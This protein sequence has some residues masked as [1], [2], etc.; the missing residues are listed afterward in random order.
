M[1]NLNA[2]PSQDS[3]DKI[4]RMNNAIVVE[5][6]Q[7]SVQLFFQS[8]Q[9]NNFCTQFPNC[10][11]EG[12]NCSSIIDLHID[13]IISKIRRWRI[14]L[15]FDVCNDVQTECDENEKHSPFFI[16]FNVRKFST[17]SIFCV[18]LS[19]RLIFAVLKSAW[20]ALQFE[21]FQYSIYAAIH[22]GCNYKK[23]KEF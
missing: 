18:T 5:R 7:Q 12:F 19:I 20:L 15:C 14:E 10:F 21:Y 23:V 2:A 13:S 3:I 8:L 1:Y 11:I 16:K 9:L 4:E 22:W 17:Y 6:F